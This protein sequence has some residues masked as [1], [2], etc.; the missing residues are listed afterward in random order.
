M[1]IFAVLG[2]GA[3]GRAVAVSLAGGGA[4]VIAID[5]DEEIIE[6]IKNDVSQAL[7]M[8]STDERAMREA[9]LEEVDVAIVAHGVRLEA[10][11]L[12]TVILRRLGVP[13]IIARSISDLHEDVLNAVGADRVVSVER[14]LG[15]QLA[16]SLLAPEITERIPLASGHSLAE[17]IPRE[18]FIGKALREID[19]RRRYGVNVVAIR[20]RRKEI[21]ESGDIDFVEEIDNTPDPDATIGEY[22]RL[23]AVGHDDALQAFGSGDKETSNH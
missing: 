4:E 2:L 12:T 14:E 5:Q 22:D 9:G 20:R 11:I 13:Q 18:E 1:K 17:I 21:T 10:S 19:A 16:G 6:G 15:A 3:F 7:R 8:N 23:L